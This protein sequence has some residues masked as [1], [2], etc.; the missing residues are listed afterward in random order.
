VAWEIIHKK[1]FIRKPRGSNL[2]TEHDN[3]KMYLEETV[4]G[5]GLDSDG[6]G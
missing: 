3:I 5:C 1:I 4:S 6:S 2:D